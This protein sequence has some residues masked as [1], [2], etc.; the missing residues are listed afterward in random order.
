MRKKMDCRDYP[1]ESKCS[2]VISGE[3]EEVVRAATDHAVSVHGHEDSP[4]LR[5]QIRT[6]LKNEMPQHA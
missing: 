4:E 3:E 5:E 6:S 2:L 1:S